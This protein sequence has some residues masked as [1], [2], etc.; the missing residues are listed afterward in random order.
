MSLPLRLG[1]VATVAL[2]ACLPVHAK[3]SLLAA[4]PT[5]PS[6]RIVVYNL[7]AEQGFEALAAQLTD[8]VLV[9]LGKD[10][11][12]QVIGESE[13]KVMVEA[14]KEKEAVTC[15]GQEACL[16]KISQAAEAEK[17]ITGR[18][19]RVGELY[20]VSLKIADAKKAVVEGGETASTEQKDGLK[21]EVLAAV[22]RLL[23]RSKGAVA[24]KFA[25]ALE[26]DGAKAAVLDLKGHDVSEGLPGNLTQ[27]LSLEL[28]KFEGLSVVSRDEIQ[29]AIRYQSEKQK[30]QCTDDTSCVIELGGMMG[31]D[32]L[33]S[34]SVGKL[35]DAFVLTLKLM[36]IVDP[37]VLNR[38]SE[39]F[40]G[41]EAH[42]PQ[43]L[44]F[45]TWRLL[46]REAE[47]NGNLAV[48]ANVDEGELVV[49]ST[50]SQPWPLKTPLSALLVGKHAVNLRSEGYFPL[51]QEAYVEPGRTTDLRLTM[52][53]V[54]R[55]WYKQWWPW[56]IMGTVVA[57]G[58]ITTA[59]LLLETPGTGTVTATVR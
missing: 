38:V 9:A 23:G 45:A 39:T 11:T 22:D 48:Q 53:E 29:S 59:V 44:R 24:P 36:D 57:A 50:A 10:P 26:G 37:R 6:S 31:V 21:A 8:E 34:G 12:L 16:A 2:L 28:K 18:V 43:A 47:G 54:P 32:Y 33:V 40:T 25:I 42:L 30:L 51:Y 35:G 46:G 1:L 19:G 20:L 58:A 5:S 52:K 13:L 56:T 14:V 3:P 41:A 17:V 55:P 49:D 15:Q 27:L 7:V 4:L